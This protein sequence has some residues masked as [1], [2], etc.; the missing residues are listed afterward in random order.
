MAAVV[1]ELVAQHRAMHGDRGSPGSCPMMGEMRHE[2][3]GMPS[4]KME[5]GT[6]EHGTMPHD[7][8]GPSSGDTA[9]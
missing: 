4:G 7:A 9:P 8:P 5:D 3:G 6:M 2:M 1:N